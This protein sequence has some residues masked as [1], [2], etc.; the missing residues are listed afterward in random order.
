M[1]VVRLAEFRDV[2]IP[3]LISLFSLDLVLS[4]RIA[5]LIGPSSNARI[6]MGMICF[7]A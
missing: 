3:L 2:L 6:C 5:S 7:S 4:V 1:F